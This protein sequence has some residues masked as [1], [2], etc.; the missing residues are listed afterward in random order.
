MERSLTY[1]VV[2]ENLPQL[3]AEKQFMLECGEAD[4]LLYICAELANRKIMRSPRHKHI[5]QK[6]RR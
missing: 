6:L 5:F 3:L 4:H 2:Y 1:Q